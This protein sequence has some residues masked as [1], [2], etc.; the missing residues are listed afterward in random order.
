[1]PVAVGDEL[2]RAELVLS[3]SAQ[4]ATWSGIVA[5]DTAVWLRA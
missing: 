3:S 5:P 2:A 1:V 4:G